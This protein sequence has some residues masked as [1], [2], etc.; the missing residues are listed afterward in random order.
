VRANAGKYQVDGARI[1][2]IGDSAG[3]F[4]ALA[5]G[6]SDAHDFASDGPDYPVPPENNPG[7]DAKPQA[8]VDLWGS[9]ELIRDMFSSD[10]PPIMVVHGTADLQF[11]THFHMAK[12]T[13]AECEAHGIPCKFCPL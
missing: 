7:V 10:D 9:A 13:I 8:V 12:N 1:A 5:A 11:G 2:V 6:V 4:A 3:A